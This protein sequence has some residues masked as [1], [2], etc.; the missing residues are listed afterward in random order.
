[1][2]E[3]SQARRRPAAAA[4]RAPARTQ[5]HAT[6]A[7]PRRAADPAPS[8]G[9][10]LTL[11]S[12]AAVLGL[13]LCAVVLMLAYPTKEYLGQ[14]SQIAAAQAE[15]RQLGQQLQALAAAH[16][17]NLDPAQIEA[18]ARA[19][20][21]FTTP[22]T[23]NYIQLAPVVPPAKATRAGHA[24]VPAGADGSWFAT[25]WGSDTSAGS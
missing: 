12:R 2:R 21:H 23:R 10:S 5:R 1:M 11:T 20:L 4:R 22:G 16:A 9:R 15:Q 6:Q 13:T 25:L 24:I 19:R 3:T 17:R 7:R 8:S 18:Q 14:R